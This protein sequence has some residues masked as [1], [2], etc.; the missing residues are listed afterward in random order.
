MLIR[1]RTNPELLNVIN[2]FNKSFL[3]MN[4]NYMNER[5]NN[6]TIGVNAI[7]QYQLDAGT[8]TEK[9]SN[10]LRDIL[11]RIRTN[12][13]LLN[14]IIDFNEFFLAMNTI[15]VSNTFG[16]SNVTTTSSTDATCIPVT[17]VDKICANDI[18]AVV[19]IILLFIIM[20]NPY[21]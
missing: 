20:I 14:V 21:D 2:D 11:I 4:G 6:I 5:V 7:I 1:I 19:F 16:S 13:E 17:Y 10:V 15:W 3:A 8:I 12:P 18:G 9:D